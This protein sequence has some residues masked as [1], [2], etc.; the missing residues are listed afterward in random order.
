MPVFELHVEWHVDKKYLKDHSVSFFLFLRG[1]FG[2]KPDLDLSEGRPKGKLQTA[3]SFS[4]P[5]SKAA[6][7]L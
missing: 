6:F 1:K 7:P 4:H 3:D 2:S 5:V